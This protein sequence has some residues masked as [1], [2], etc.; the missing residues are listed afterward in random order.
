MTANIS[1]SAYPRKCYAVERLKQMGEWTVR[2]LEEI[3]EAQFR[4]LLYFT[5]TGNPIDPYQV[6]VNTTRLPVYENVDVTLSEV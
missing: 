6:W 2:E 4:N 3:G 1:N 5:L